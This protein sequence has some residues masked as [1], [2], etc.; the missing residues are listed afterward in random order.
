MLGAGCLAIVAVMLV[1]SREVAESLLFTAR[2]FPLPFIGIVV[3]ASVLGILFARFVWRQPP[4]VRG[5]LL[6][7]GGLY[8]LGA[9]AL[10]LVSEFYCGRRH[11]PG[12]AVIYAAV[13]TA[14][15]TCEML[16]ILLS[17][18]A[19]RLHRFA[20]GREAASPLVCG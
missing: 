20:L 10:E 1:G 12:V 13:S 15:E 19:L 17:I 2:R 14:E 16:G 8:L 9:V 11:E 4:S 18:R 6:V 5:R 7:A 3:V